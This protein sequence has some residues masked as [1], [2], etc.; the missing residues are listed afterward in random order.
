MAGMPIDFSLIGTVLAV[1]LAIL[2]LSGIALYIAFRLRETLKEERGRGA[3]VVKLAFLIGLLFL[4]GGVFYFFAAG[5]HSPSVTKGT[6]TPTISSTTTV[7]TNPGNHKISVSTNSNTS[8]PPSTTTSS[9]TTISTNMSSSS[10]TSSTITTTSS[11][12]VPSLSMLLSYPSSVKNGSTF[13]FSFTII[14]NGSATADSVTIQAGDILNSFSL[15][16]SNYPIS[17]NVIELGNISPGTIVASLQ[18]I[19]PKSGQVS[20]T[21]TLTYQQMSQPV[22]ESF[23]IRVS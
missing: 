22:V 10:S 2:A 8:M 13:T 4:S 21:T 14:N 20:G 9:S 6:T 15:V 12:Q 16:N 23:A 11:S 17:G 18:L 19:A 3:R 1:S 5:F 7:T